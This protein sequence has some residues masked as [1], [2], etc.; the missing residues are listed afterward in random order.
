MPWGILMIPVLKPMFER[1]PENS[2]VAP[3]TIGHSMLAWL[4]WF[5]I[6]N[7]SLI[8]LSY[9]PE[10]VVASMMPMPFREPAPSPHDPPEFE[11]E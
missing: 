11:F 5:V 8:H 10:L 1:S 4:Q 9:A 6:L 3:S 2:K 7:I